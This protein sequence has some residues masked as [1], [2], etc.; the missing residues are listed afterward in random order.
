MRASSDLLLGMSIEAEALLDPLG[1]LLVLGLESREKHV[2]QCEQGRQG[3]E[4]F[5]GIDGHLGR[6]QRLF[7]LSDCWHGCFRLGRLWF[8]S[9]WL[10]FGRG[11]W[12][13]ATGPR[14]LTG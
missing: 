6:G 8:A 11:R 4:D 14:T 10:C 5:H 13:T 1:V 7:L 9:S 2:E 3:E 12:S